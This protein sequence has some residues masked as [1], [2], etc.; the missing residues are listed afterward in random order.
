MKREEINLDR[1]TIKNRLRGLDFD[2]LIPIWNGYC[3]DNR[4]TESFVFCNDDTELD[5]NFDGMPA[6]EIIRMVSYGD[7]NFADEYFSFNGYGNLV[8]F[9][10]LE[11]DKCTICVEDLANWLEGNDDLLE[12]Y[13]LNYD[14]DEEDDDDE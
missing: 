8:S 4:D 12:Q 5:A 14:D 13:G 1:E 2:A 7:Y 9:E 6:H 10:S 11:D 3:D